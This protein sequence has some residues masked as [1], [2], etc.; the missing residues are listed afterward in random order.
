MTGE[1]ASDTPTTRSTFGCTT[2]MVV[3]ARLQP[4]LM[5][6]LSS[7][8]VSS[9]QSAQVPLGFVPMKSDRLVLYGPEGGVAPL[10]EVWNGMAVCKGVGAYVPVT[11]AFVVRKLP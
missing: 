4:L 7:A 1:G 11:G 8:L 3:K 9:T 5:V 10:V 6:P 2:L